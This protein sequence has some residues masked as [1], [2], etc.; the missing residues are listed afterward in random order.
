[1]AGQR[2]KVKKYVIS[3]VRFSALTGHAGRL[4]NVLMPGTASATDSAP[5]GFGAAAGSPPNAAH[6]PTATT[7]S[8]SLHIS[9]AICSAERPPIVQYAPPAP[10]GIEPSITTMYVP[11]WFVCTDSSA[12]SARAPA[13][14]MSVSW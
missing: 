7:A 5:V 2:L 13:A 14:A 3:A 6:V 8:A 9:S 4:I 12:A 10:V 1:K 11:L